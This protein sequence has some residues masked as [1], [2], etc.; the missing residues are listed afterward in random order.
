M[1]TAPD[2]GTVP[3]EPWP[4]PFTATDNPPAPPAVAA[5]RA[6]SRRSTTTLSP[7]GTTPR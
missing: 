2:P 1:S 5:H 7:G 4:L 6:G 3:P